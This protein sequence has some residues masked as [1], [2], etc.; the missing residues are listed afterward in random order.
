MGD[1][2]DFGA[3]PTRRTRPSSTR[4]NKTSSSSRSA[5]L[6]P[7]QTSTTRTVPTKTSTATVQ[8]AAQRARSKLRSAAR[9]SPV[10]S[11]T[12]TLQPTS[13]RGGSTT[14]IIPST[15]QPG[16]LTNDVRSKGLP[17]DSYVTPAETDE[18]PVQRTSPKA[19]TSTVT[20]QATVA[21]TALSTRR[22][23]QAAAAAAATTTATD[24]GTYSSDSGSSGGGGSMDDGSGEEPF[25]EEAYDEEYAED[26]YEEEYADEGEWIDE[27][28]RYIDP[29]DS[30]EY[31]DE[32]A[33][34]TY[35]PE[36]PQGF[37]WAWSE[38][39]DTWILVPMD[40]GRVESEGAVFDEDYNEDFEDGFG[41]EEDEAEFGARV[42]L[43][44]IDDQTDSM[45][46]V[47]L[48]V[49]E[50]DALQSLESDW[51]DDWASPDDDGYDGMDDG[52]EDDRP[53]GYSYPD[54]D[55]IEVPVTFPRNRTITS[56]TL[57]HAFGAEESTN[58]L[59]DFINTLLPEGGKNIGKSTLSS[60]ERTTRIK[61][62][63][64][65][66]KSGL[67]GLA[68][69]VEM[70]PQPAVRS[71]NPA[72]AAPGSWTNQDIKDAYARAKKRAKEAALSPKKYGEKLSLALANVSEANAVINQLAPGTVRDDLAQRLFEVASGMF[73]MA[74]TQDG[75]GVS[76]YDMISMG[77]V[78][79]YIV[80]INGIRF[81]TV[82]AAFAWEILGLL[83]NLLA[84]ARDALSME[85]R[86][87]PGGLDRAKPYLTTGAVVGLGV[88]GIATILLLTRKK[89]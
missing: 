16:S 51:R 10:T 56:S 43:S 37:V 81:D 59:Q 77:E 54:E 83:S 62:L 6:R 27:E 14:P 88:A 65:S 78:V 80:T 13:P 41:P 79:A 26:A 74:S 24:T 47:P 68:D 66:V 44:V 33:G 22:A 4:S 71:L 52:G 63:G 49:D 53:T 40:E 34:I 70:I 12:S 11:T 9:P 21:K 73:G 30:T 57:V 36:A 19:T 42:V 31:V 76:G 7:T 23:E 38:E 87:L 58:L 45:L 20:E 86:G 64:Q 2:M 89:K 67:P 46:S 61:N 50:A 39:Q 17:G 84:S 29:V 3:R 18:T 25:E 69:V 85:S 5:L 15:Y 72:W 75:Q 35:L 32:D 55:L 8:S 28:A 60:E 1:E 48:N 82:A